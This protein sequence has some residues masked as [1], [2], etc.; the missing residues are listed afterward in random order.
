M[1]YSFTATEYN[2]D[3]VD[4]S[5]TTLRGRTEHWFDL[6]LK[7]YTVYKKSDSTPTETISMVWEENIERINYFV[8][9]EADKVYA[10]LLNDKARLYE[11]ANFGQFV[12]RTP[13]DFK[14]TQANI[15]KSEET[16]S[17][18]KNYKP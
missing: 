2:S 3:N 12:S 13:D 16:L 8:Q 9:R 17:F 6:T 14:D 4:S 15:K 18:L 10:Q 7:T 11:I 1:D 5:F